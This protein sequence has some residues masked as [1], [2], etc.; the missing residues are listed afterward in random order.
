MSSAQGSAVGVGQQARTKPAAR[1][2]QVTAGEHG[3]P[4]VLG[5]VEA[6]E[7][8]KH[9]PQVPRGRVPVHRTCASSM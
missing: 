2:G 7:V 6:P 9:A 8:P 1:P 4:G 3:L 5:Q